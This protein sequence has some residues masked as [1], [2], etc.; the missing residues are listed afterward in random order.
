MSDLGVTIFL[1]VCCYP[2]L[3]IMAAVMANEAKPKKNIVI[4]CTLP[5][6]AQ[7]DPRVQ[8]I[9][10]DYKRRIWLLFFILT[11]AIVPAFVI[12]RTSLALAWLFFWVL[13]ALVM[14]FVVF[15]RF[16][17]RLRALKAQEGWVTPYSGAVVVDIG[18]KPEELGKPLSRWLFIPPLLVSLI[19][20]A[21]AMAS[22]NEGERMGGLILGLTFALCCLMSL[23]FYP[24]VFR[25]RPDV[26]DSDSRVNAALTRVRRYNW[27]KTWIAMS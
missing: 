24:L 3:P 20:C 6:T 12:K 7:H 4:G 13:V 18:A 16:N 14:F 1:L 23:F 15:A 11:A 8:G 9:C 26:V 5:L 25:Q 17:V 27:G 19:P 2:V 10:R 21:L 22:G